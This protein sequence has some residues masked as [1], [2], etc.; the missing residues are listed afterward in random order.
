MCVWIDNLDIFMPHIAL[1]TKRDIRANEELTFDYK[2]D[3]GRL[4]EL[5]EE[6]TEEERTEEEIPTT[7]R[8][9]SGI[10]S[11]SDQI[12][13]TSSLARVQCKCGANNCRI[14]LY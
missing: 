5:S 4:G 3:L 12:V 13:K 8:D 11:E 14:Y 9:D 2:M 6:K 1:F 10:G 7:S